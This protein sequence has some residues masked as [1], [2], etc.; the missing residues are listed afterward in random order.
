MVVGARQ[1]VQEHGTNMASVRASVVNQ[2]RMAASRVP[3]S[4]DG[5]AVVESGAIEQLL[6]CARLSPNP[7]RTLEWALESLRT[8]PVAGT[9]QVACQLLRAARA[10]LEVTP[11]A[12]REEQLRE[13][14]SLA[15]A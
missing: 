9:D 1:R 12:R 6:R 11:V 7:V 5:G 10:R 2:A 15:W 4:T 13:T 14:P 8:H 3:Q